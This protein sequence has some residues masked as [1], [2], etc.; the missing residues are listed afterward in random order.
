MRENLRS[1]FRKHG[2]GEG[3]NSEGGGR[4][5]IQFPDQNWTKIDRLPPVRGELSIQSP[6]NQLPASKLDQRDLNSLGIPFDP[7]DF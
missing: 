5:E 6:A 3:G 1:V 2:R 4:R 7:N